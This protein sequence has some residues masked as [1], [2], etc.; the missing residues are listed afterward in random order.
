MAKRLHVCVFALLFSV[1]VMTFLSPCFA[2]DDQV[3]ENYSH[4][5]RQFLLT[6]PTQLF[7][8]EAPSRRD[9]LKKSGVSDS[10]LRDIKDTL[11]G[12]SSGDSSSFSLIDSS[13]KVPPGLLDGTVTSFGDFDQCLAVSART[14]NSFSGKY[15]PVKFLPHVDR[16]TQELD[17]FVENKIPIFEYYTLHVGLCVPSTCSES[18]VFQIFNV[19]FEMINAPF[20]PIDEIIC[21]VKAE[22]TISYKV[23]QLNFKQRAAFI[24]LMVV[25]SVSI[26]GTAVTYFKP[27]SSIMSPS[28]VEFLSNFN[29]IQNAKVLFIPRSKSGNRI[30]YI[31]YMRLLIIACGIGGHCMSCLETVDGWYIIHR[32][33]DL[34]RIFQEVWA[35]PLMNEAGL[36]IVTFVAGFST[37]WG[38]YDIIQKGNFRYRMAVFERVLRYLP[39]IVC[40]LAID[41][42]FPLYGD[43]PIFKK[44]AQ[45]VVWKCSKNWWMNFMFLSNYESCV[46]ACTAHTFFSSIDLQLF[47]IGLVVVY[48]LVRNRTLGVMSCFFLIITGNILLA[49]YTYSKATSPVLIDA[50]GSVQKSVNYLNYVHFATY[51]HFSNYFIGVLVAFS[52]KATNIYSTMNLGL[53]NFL[54]ICSFLVSWTNHFAPAL[55]NSFGLVPPTMVPVYLVTTKFLFVFWF[56][57]LIF[58]Y[59]PMNDKKEREKIQ[60]KIIISKNGSYNQSFLELFRDAN[61]YVN[62]TLLDVQDLFHPILSVYSKMTVSIYLINYVLIRVDFFT[63]RVPFALT[64]YSF[65]K[66]ILYTLGFTF[67][68][69]VI[70]HLFFFAP[71]DNIRKSFKIQLDRSKISQGNE[72]RISITNGKIKGKED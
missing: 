48:L 36:G 63:S 13:G 33:H 4:R 71:F 41:I 44:V 70:F 59:F 65:S 17:L 51:S 20:R 42:L 57:Y 49:A 31:D 23:D 25:M 45:H 69:G 22:N 18:D 43:G 37:F 14:P 67:V 60:E 52:L 55:H 61:L 1:T 68:A 2:S 29:L 34:T 62:A 47:M 7:W 10:C 15:C 9:L 38:T 21:Q 11:A 54:L 6:G 35:Q 46:D 16:K 53:K 12:V 40:L 3:N 19:T 5:L 32:L 8:Q 56:A 27:S 50:H 28:T 72:E 30:Q 66:R 39:A 24:F 58:Y 64:L 26:V